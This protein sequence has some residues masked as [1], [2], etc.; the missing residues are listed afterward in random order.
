[1]RTL[2]NKGYFWQQELNPSISFQYLS[3]IIIGPFYYYCQFHM[4]IHNI[5]DL[6]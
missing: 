6:E 4:Q 5:C 1:M 2:S 3:V